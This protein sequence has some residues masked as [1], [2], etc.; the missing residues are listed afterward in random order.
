MLPDRLD[1]LIAHKVINLSADLSGA[2]KCVAGAIIDHF[3]RKT[4]QCDPGIDRLSRLLGCSRRTVIRAVESLDEH[5]LIYC[6]RHGGRSQRNSYQPNWPLFRELD[7]AWSKAMSGNSRHQPVTKCASPERQS[8]HLGSDRAVTQTLPTNQSIEPVTAGRPGDHRRSLGK[9]AHPEGHARGRTLQTRK[10]SIG[11]PTSGTSRRQAASTIAERRIWSALHE[12]FAGNRDCFEVL[13]AA[14][15][16]SLSDAAVAVELKQRGAGLG[17]ILER[18][19]ER[20]ALPDVSEKPENSAA[21]GQ[22][23][24]EVDHG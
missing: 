20:N 4:G 23:Y 3:N 16:Q 5:E 21:Y 19:S 9:L 24:R 14:I 15:D 6:R 8:C 1:T 22:V 17:Y 18:L 7:E 11:V 13:V 12:R 10:P 2:D